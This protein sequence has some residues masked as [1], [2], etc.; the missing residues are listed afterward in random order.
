KSVM[1][2]GAADDRRYNSLFRAKRVEW[3]ESCRPSRRQPTGE[4]DD[5]EQDRGHSAENSRIMRTD[6]VQQRLHHATADEGRR[7]PDGDAS[8]CDEAPLPYD[9]PRH[10]C[11]LRAERQAHTN[12]PGTLA[13][14]VRHRAVDADDAE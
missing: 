14:D 12:F 4:E 6:A 13:D 1:R 2:L 9:H 7:K 11:R 10:T 3:A 5:A 8:Q